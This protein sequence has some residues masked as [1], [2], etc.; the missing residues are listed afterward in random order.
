MDVLMNEDMEYVH[1][2]STVQRSSDT[3]CDEPLP[4]YSAY[5]FNIPALLPQSE[6]V[7]NYQTVPMDVRN[8]R[9]TLK[10]IAASNKSVPSLINILGTYVNGKAA[11]EA[12]LTPDG[13]PLQFCYSRPTLRRY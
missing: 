4:T 3:A 13:I 2:G 1:F 7:V 8:C 12:W 5:G 9:H 10:A 11:K 6:M